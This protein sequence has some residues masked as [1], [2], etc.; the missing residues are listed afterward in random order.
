MSPPAT[1]QLTSP[2]SP[3]GSRIID[4]RGYLIENTTIDPVSGKVVVPA[5]FTLGGVIFSTRVE[6]SHAL[7]MDDYYTVRVTVTPADDSS[8]AVMTTS[9]IRLRAGEP[10][11]EVFD[12]ALP[13]PGTGQR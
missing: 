3:P 11:T 2:R 12:V 1:A 9:R 5:E 10:I 4:I 13:K 8:R 7:A 6:Q